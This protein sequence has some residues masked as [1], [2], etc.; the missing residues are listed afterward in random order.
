MSG[1]GSD[2]LV[3][4]AQIVNLRG[5]HARASAALARLATSFQADLLIH[6]DGEVADARSIMDLLML[7]AYKGSVVRIEARGA[8]AEPAM[9]A[10]CAL[11]ADGFG[12]AE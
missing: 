9:K 5:L 4:E 8:D 11:I 6:H 3:G 2:G 7:C 1:D 10:I 12:E